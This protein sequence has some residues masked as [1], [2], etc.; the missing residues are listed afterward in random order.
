MTQCNTSTMYDDSLSVDK[1]RPNIHVVI[2]AVCTSGRPPAANN[3]MKFSALSTA[4]FL[5]I[6]VASAT[7]VGHT[8]SAD[9]AI[10]QNLLK[11]ARQLN[12]NNNYYYAW[13]SGYSVKFDGC[14]AVPSFEREEG[15]GAELMA[16]FKLCPTS[17]G[18]G[19]CRNSGEYVVNM[20]DFI[21]SM[22]KADEET[23]QYQMEDCQYKCEN[24]YYTASAAYG[25]DAAANEYNYYNGNGN[26]NNNNNN[27]NQDDGNYCQ[28]QCLVD[29][30]Y[31]QCNNG[32]QEGGEGQVDVNELAECRPMNEEGGGGN[33][34]N[35]NAYQYNSG[36][37]QIYYVGAYCTSSG[38]YAGVFT[39]SM[40][41]KHAPSG[42]YEKYNYGYSL[43]T[44]PLV[45][46]E[47]LTCGVSYNNNGNNNNNNNN[48]GNGDW[49]GNQ[50]LEVCEELYESAVKCESNVKNTQYQDTTGCEMIHTI[51]PRMNATFKS[52]TGF[53]VAKFFAWT[54][55]LAFFALG[56]YVYLLHKKV[57]RQKTELAA[58]GYG[59]APSGKGVPA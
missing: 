33:N 43:P 16:K 54:F 27:N 42:T 7:A 3:N 20:R 6:S 59:E 39:D 15:M 50:I 25:D 18:C 11:S 44:T 4:I 19:S 13:I 5:G 24:G 22:Q 9:S 34:N 48:G 37:Y 14:V 55:G 12:D 28:Y 58:L 35:N 32:Q 1:T 40:C 17:G 38:V 2:N 21:E 47:C 52:V 10:G 51:L 57:V 30:G 36:N 23:C 8:L 26:N 56:G 53:P 49:N 29:A 41:T 31:G 46:T 45:S